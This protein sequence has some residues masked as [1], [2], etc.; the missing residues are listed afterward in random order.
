MILPQSQLKLIKFDILDFHMG[1][2][3]PK[4]SIE[5]LDE[6]KYV[7]DL[8]FKITVDK[9]SGHIFVYT[10]VI[11]NSPEAKY[12]CHILDVD[13]GTVFYI[14]P[15]SG[16]TEENK[17]LMIK[18]SAVPIAFNNVRGFIQN[19]TSYSPIGVY[20]LPLFSASTLMQNQFK[21]SPP[22][23]AKVKSTSVTKQTK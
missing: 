18:A 16:I 12:P 11:V 9:D 2:I 8:K 19:A 13:A 15:S 7:L 6:D 23:A 5:E 22:K 1:Y 3:A 10:S 20:M 4:E 14:D 17:E 21:K